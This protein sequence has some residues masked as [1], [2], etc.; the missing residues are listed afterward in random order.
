MCTVAGGGSGSQPVF[1]DSSQSSRSPQLYT[2][3]LPVFAL[4]LPQRLYAS[5]AYIFHPSHTAP[6]IQ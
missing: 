3:A 4:T 5:L 1:I 2:P 6:S